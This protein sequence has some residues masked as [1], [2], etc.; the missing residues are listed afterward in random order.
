MLRGSSVSPCLVTGLLLKDGMGVPG[1]VRRTPSA[2]AWSQ[3]SQAGPS[4]LDCL[5]RCI[6]LTGSL[7]AQTGWFWAVCQGFPR[8]CSWWLIGNQRRSQPTAWTVSNDGDGSDSEAREGPG[9]SLGA[10]H[11]PRSPNPTGVSGWGHLGPG[12]STCGAVC[13]LTLASVSSPTQPPWVVACVRERMS[14]YGSVSECV[15]RRSFW[16]GDPVEGA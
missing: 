4:C 11:P 3:R 13:V 14:M 2:C 6:G 10:P 8:P 1:T 16:K 12:E 15:H 7:A 9:W 5:G